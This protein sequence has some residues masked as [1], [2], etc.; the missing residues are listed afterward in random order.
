MGF[1]TSN[2]GH[3]I[4]VRVDLTGEIINR[5]RALCIL[6]ELANFLLFNLDKSW[7][8]NL[9]WVLKAGSL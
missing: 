5:L 3:G 4:F 7:L 9:L 1:G 8:L 2:L 6:N